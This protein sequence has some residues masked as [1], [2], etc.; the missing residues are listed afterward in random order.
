MSGIPGSYG[1][2]IYNFSRNCQTVFQSSCT[3][4]TFFKFSP[5]V[6]CA[7]LFLFVPLVLYFSFLF[8]AFLLVTCAFFVEFQFD[9]S[10]V[11][12]NVFLCVAFVSGTYITY[13]ST[14]FPVPAN[15]RNLIFFYLLLLIIEFEN[16]M[17]QCCNFCSNCQTHSNSQERAAPGGPVV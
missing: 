15:W 12:L 11:F 4:Y 17:R 10:I 9:L 8:P 2:F 5:M 13:Q 6:V 16:Y 1:K 7:C 14:F 3:T